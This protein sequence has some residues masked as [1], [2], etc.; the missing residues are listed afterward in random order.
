MW[1]FSSAD[2]RDTARSALE[3]RL[4]STGQACSS[5]KRLI[6]MDD[7]FDEFLDEPVTRVGEL[8]AADPMQAEEPTFGPLSSEAAA[9]ALLD[10]IGDAV[11]HG[12]L[13]HVGGERLDREGFFV[14][15]SVITGVTGQARAY[16]EELFGPAVVVYRVSSDEEALR[17][18][19]D[20]AYG[21][22]AAVYAVEPGRAEVFG[23]ETGEDAAESEG[24]GNAEA[25]KYRRRLRDTEA[26][27]EQLTTE[28]DEAAQALAELRDAIAT[29][30]LE[31]ALTP[32]IPDEEMRRIVM[33]HV[34]L[35]DFQ[36]EAGT[37]DRRAVAEYAQRFTPPVTGWSFVPTG[38]D[39]DARSTRSSTTWPKLLGGG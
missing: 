10:Q 33:E 28:R 9:D 19:N 15:P 38:Y 34:H 29:E 16:R 6:V 30:A 11:E 35:A 8:T 2:P 12:A 1:A 23:E 25:A 39:R 27:V 26:Q 5:N 4:E 31:D 13:V 14:S 36:T 7:V 18:A 22:G 20:T 3:I 32:R 21:L 24:G 17:L 37:V